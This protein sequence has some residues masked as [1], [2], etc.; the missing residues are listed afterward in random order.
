MLG[1]LVVLAALSVIGGW[2]GIPEALGGHSSFEHYLA[3]AITSA[4][5]GTPAAEAM[6]AAEHAGHSTELAFAGISVG[7]A[8]L[9]FFLAW[10][11]YYKR[12]E[13][14][15]KVTAKAR[16]LYLMV[17][18]KYYID[19]GYDQLFVKPLLWISRQVLWLFVDQKV[20]DG[21][22]NGAGSVSQGIGGQLRRMQSGNIRSYAAW[23]AAGAA[24]V[25][26]FM[27]WRGVHQ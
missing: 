24:A 18:H 25:V 13:L 2:V 12:P 1:P 7:V 10:F 9:G 6:E 14:P 26:A 15:E 20:I 3:P 5:P 23:I 22:V 4:V 8:A 27:I 19:E 16:G 17:L 11:F 21:T